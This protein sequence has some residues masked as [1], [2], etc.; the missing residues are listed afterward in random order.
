MHL[1]NTDVKHVQRKLVSLILGVDYVLGGASV[2]TAAGME[3]AHTDGRGTPTA[4]RRRILRWQ[5]TSRTSGENLTNATRLSLNCLNV[6]RCGV[7]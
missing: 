7:F 1:L 3:L 4:N 5:V 6:E 2:F